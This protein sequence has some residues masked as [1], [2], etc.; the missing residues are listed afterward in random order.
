M[1]THYIKIFNYKSMCLVDVEKEPWT[2]LI[3]SN[4]QNSTFEIVTITLMEIVSMQVFFFI[5]GSK[6]KNKNE[7][8]KYHGRFIS[9]KSHLYSKPESSIFLFLDHGMQNTM[10]PSYHSKVSSTENQQVPFFS[11]L[12]NKFSITFSWLGKVKVFLIILTCQS[13]S[14][15]NACMK[16]VN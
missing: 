12:V 16:R 15:F 9:F 6:W 3:I 10:A 5:V 14:T 11:C 1:L 2:Y 4:Y 13:Q 7:N 8:T